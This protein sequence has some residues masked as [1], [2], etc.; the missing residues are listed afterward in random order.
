MSTENLQPEH[1]DDGLPAKVAS[2][3]SLQSI[4]ARMAS[5]SQLMKT[6][7]ITIVTGFIAIKSTFGGLGSIS[8]MVP[9]LL[10]LSFSYLDSY[11]LSQERI[12]RDVY[13]NQAKIPVGSN[14]NYLDFKDLIVECS[15]QEKNSVKS[16]I[17]SPS[18][19]YFYI[20]MVIIATVILIKG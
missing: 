5:N 7:A 19:I 4:I 15:K 2:L 13:N 10:C 17:K 9:F 1:R 16:C 12:F 14:V 3:A 18:V 20:P 8:Y 6:W 11:Y